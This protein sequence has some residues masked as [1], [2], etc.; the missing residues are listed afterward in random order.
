M[1][2]YDSIERGR[3][4]SPPIQVLASGV[5][6]KQNPKNEHSKPN[7]HRHLQKQFVSTIAVA[8]EINY[9][10]V[11]AFLQIVQDNH[12]RYTKP[13]FPRV[14]VEIARLLHPIETI[15]VGSLLLNIG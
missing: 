12:V 13:P 6:G 14:L 9:T 15:P 10:L 7:S 11:H 8:M 4:E 2:W 5:T 3:Q 1:E